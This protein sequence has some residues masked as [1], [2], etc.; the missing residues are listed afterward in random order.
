MLMF[1]VEITLNFLPV[2]SVQLRN[3]A[4]QNIIMT[5]LCRLISSGCRKSH[6]QCTFLGKEFHIAILH[7]RTKWISKYLCLHITTSLHVYIWE[8]ILLQ[9]KGLCKIKLSKDTLFTVLALEVPV[10]EQL[11]SMFFVVI[12]ILCLIKHRQIFCVSIWLHR[13]H[14]GCKW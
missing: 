13:S 14:L 9:W 10:F 2:L 1:S 5:K 8:T 12:M 6:L 4:H 7:C 3:L 11:I